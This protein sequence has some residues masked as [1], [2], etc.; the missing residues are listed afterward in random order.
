M[1]PYEKHSGWLLPVVSRA[2]K[3]I[4][5]TLRTQEEPEGRHRIKHKL[6]K[7]KTKRAPEVLLK[8][9]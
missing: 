5:H 6:K 2:V 9:F 4:Y 1:S 7:K 3:A 8:E